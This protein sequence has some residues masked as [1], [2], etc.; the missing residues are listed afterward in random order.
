M[1]FGTEPGFSSMLKRREAEEREK[2][3]WYRRVDRKR[4]GIG[5]EI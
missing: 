4:E 3:E 5:W 2:R 1:W